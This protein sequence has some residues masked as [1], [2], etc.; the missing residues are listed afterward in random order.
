MLEVK[1]NK[2]KFMIRDSYSQQWFDKNINLGNWESYTFDIIDKFTNKDKIYIDIGAW[3]GPTVLYASTLSKNVFCF[4]PDP[5]ALKR[6]KDNI[7][8]NKINNICVIDKCLSDKIE[9]TKFGGRGPLGN[10]AS[11]MLLS[12]HS[13]KNDVVTV[14]CI[15]FEKFISDNNINLHDISLI[16]MDIEG[17]EKI[18]IP[19]MMSYFKKHNIKIPLYISLHWKPLTKEDINNILTLL[20]DH[21][22]NC[23]LRDL[24][25]KVNIDDIVNKG[26]GGIIFN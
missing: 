25:T 15:T 23:F 18:V 11:T 22:N 17:G 14:Q 12:E 24:K 2:A 8:C 1:K 5:I 16:K 4:E 26:Y 6:L 21:Y 19:S 10:S 13:N 9:T 20:F 7:D 3:I